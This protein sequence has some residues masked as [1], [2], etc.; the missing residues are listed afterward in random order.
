[1]KPGCYGSAICYSAS[2]AVCIS[3]AYR[4]RCERV[5]IALESQVIRKVKSIRTENED[6]EKSEAVATKLRRYF[7]RRQLSKN[8]AAMNQMSPRARRD[9]DY[10][11]KRGVDFRAIIEGRNPFDDENRLAYLKHAVD[12]LLEF[13]AVKRKDVAEYLTE[14][15]VES[16]STMASYA[17]NMFTAL[18]VVEKQERAMYCLAK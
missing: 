18:G 2:S 4:A 6:V 15:G 13:R 11:L 12:R 16:A 14:M 3:C 17:L 9:Y 1:M 7:K 10:C 8:E 5:A